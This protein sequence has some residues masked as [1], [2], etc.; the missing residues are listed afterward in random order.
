MVK[1]KGKVS[2]LMTKSVCLDCTQKA[3][4]C[5][6]KLYTTTGCI[7]MTDITIPIEVIGQ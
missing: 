1:A 2:D 5:L 6:W 7:R 3:A 4:G